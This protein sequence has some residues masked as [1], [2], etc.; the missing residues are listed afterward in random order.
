MKIVVNKCYGGFGLSDWAMEQLGIEYSWDIDRTQP[1]LISLVENFPKKV[2]D[3]FS[4]LSVVEIPDNFT[5]LEIS[6]YDGF[7][8]VT[9]V[10]DGK[11]KH[12]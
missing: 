8:T 11:I 5:D 2:N 3:V 6:D 10:V 7:E 12:I 1:N 4:E 9:Y